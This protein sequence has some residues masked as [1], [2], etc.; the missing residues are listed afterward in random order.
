MHLIVNRI[1]IDMDEQMAELD[2]TDAQWKPMLFLSVGTAR[3]GADMVQTLGCDSGAVTRM[4]DRLETKGFV[5]RQRNLDDR[6]VTDVVLTELGQEVANKIPYA[7]SGV[8]NQYFSVFSHE[9]MAIFKRL[10]LKVVNSEASEEFNRN[11]NGKG[12]V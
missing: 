2:L 3:C 9:E 4:L 10:L 12:A 1:R 8:L 11:N 5:R 6:R 7:V